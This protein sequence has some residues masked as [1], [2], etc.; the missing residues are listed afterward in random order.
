MHYGG[1]IKSNNRIEADQTKKEENTELGAALVN[2]LE[3]QIFFVSR[4]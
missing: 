1:K 4:L 2:L 3:M